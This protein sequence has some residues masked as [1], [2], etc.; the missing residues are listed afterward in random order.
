MVLI[1][2]TPL[3]V[4]EKMLLAKITP[5]WV[6]GKNAFY[7][8]NKLHGKYRKKLFPKKTPYDYE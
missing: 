2:I 1:Q 7:Q 4:R 6:E 8:N 5:P 3:R